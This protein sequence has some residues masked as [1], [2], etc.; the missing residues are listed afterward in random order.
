MQDQVDEPDVTQL[1]TPAVAYTMLLEKY[2]CNVFNIESTSEI[3]DKVKARDI[4]ERM[5]RVDTVKEQVRSL[6]SASRMDLYE[7]CYIIS[8]VF[9]EL[10]KTMQSVTLAEDFPFPEV[11]SFFEDNMLLFLG[12][13]KKVVR[14]ELIHNSDSNI[15]VH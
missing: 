6:L 10:H 8:L 11:K 4:S 5:E 3:A 12:H 9:D 1:T 13:H 15:T 14:E 2:I 7:L